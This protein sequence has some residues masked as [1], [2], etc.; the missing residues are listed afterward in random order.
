M[1]NAVS[2]AYTH[3]H[4][5][6]LSGNQQHLKNKF[7]GGYR[8]CVS[9]EEENEDEVNNMI[10]TLFPTATTTAVYKGTREYHITNT[11]QSPN[12]IT[13]T[14]TGGPNSKYNYHTNSNN[15]NGFVSRAFELLEENS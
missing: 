15:N 5:H 12:K 14:E 7:G 13:V 3:T 1:H 10:K 2:R 6:T 4:A 9:F 8:L 11:L